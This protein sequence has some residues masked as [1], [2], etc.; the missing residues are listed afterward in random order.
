VDATG[1]V[2][3]MINMEFVV[4]S[5]KPK[6][7]HYEMPYFVVQFETENGT[8]NLKIQKSAL[9]YLADEIEKLSS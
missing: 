5:I 2:T 8:L 7:V 9:D 3:S 1:A 6:V 4:T